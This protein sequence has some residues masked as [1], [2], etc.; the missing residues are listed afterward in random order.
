MGL[1]PFLGLSRRIGED[2]YNTGRILAAMVTV[3][4]PGC[5]VTAEVLVELAR[6]H[7]PL[8]GGWQRV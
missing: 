3:F 5:P 4:P 7:Q 2:F 6:E 1:T 8:A